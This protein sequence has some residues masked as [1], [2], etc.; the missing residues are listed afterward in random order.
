MEEL[1]IAF[2]IAGFQE[3][4]IK[5]KIVKYQGELAMGKDEK[6]YIFN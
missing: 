1:Q 2:D 3:Y 4:F 5:Y 6:Y